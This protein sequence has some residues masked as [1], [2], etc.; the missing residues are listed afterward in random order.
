MPADSIASL[1][2]SELLA[3]ATNMLSK[4]NSSPTTYG[5]TVTYAAEL[6]AKRDQFNTELND[7]V[8]KQ[9]DAKAQT[10]KKDN[11]RS[12]LESII[13]DGRNLAKAAKIPE[14]VYAELG[15]PSGS[16]PAPSNVTV[17]SALIDMRERLRH[18][19]SWTDA[20]SLDNK[21]KPRGVM[22]AEIWVKI[23]DPP[24]GNEKDCVFLTLDAFTPYVAEYDPADAGKM[25]HYMIRWRM[26][27]GSVSAWGETVSATIT[28]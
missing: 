8:T 21:K 18:K 2:D 22:G 14:A 23:G 24:P 25:A 20:A 9:A 16:A 10:L 15:I 5:L 13:R 6:D 28:G 11:A 7:H 3:M 1:S 26:R 17:P 12:V 4:V 27:D 19:L